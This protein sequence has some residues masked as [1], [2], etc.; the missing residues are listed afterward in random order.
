VYLNDLADVC[1]LSGLHV[2]EV[3]GWQSRGHGGFSALESLICHHTAGPRTGAYPSLGVVRDGRPG[4]DGPLAQIGLGRD[5]KVYVIAAGVAWHAGTVGNRAHDNWH[6]L[7]IEAEHDGVSPWPRDLYAAYVRL[8]AALRTGY[9]IPLGRVLGHKEIAVPKGRKIDPNFDMGQFRRAVGRTDV[10][11]LASAGATQEDDDMPTAEEIAEALLDS[12][13]NVHDPK[14][15]K[16]TRRTTL[17]EELTA[18]GIF[19][20]NTPGPHQDY[21]ERARKSRVP[22]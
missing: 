6:A 18:L 13:I 11:K 15:Q 22:K 5:L 7:G 19:L 17:R 16:E 9:G 1:R 14:G 8:A 4:L 12:A 21:M 10:S 20:D 2:V 3:G